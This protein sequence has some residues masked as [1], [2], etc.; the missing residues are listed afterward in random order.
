MRYDRPSGTYGRLEGGDTTVGMAGGQAI[1][2][3]SMGWR[4]S[5]KLIREPLVHFLLAGALM[6]G[7]HAWLNRAPP[8]P[9]ARDAVRI[10]A[11]ESGVAA[12]NLRQPV[13]A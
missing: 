9:D 8:R 4:E 11:G 6:F 12:A 3:N 10:G 7:A 5:L 1:A 13:A 2:C